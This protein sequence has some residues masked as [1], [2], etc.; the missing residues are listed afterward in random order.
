[1]NASV[2]GPVYLSQ[3]RLCTGTNMPPVT[4][5]RSVA[6]ESMRVLTTEADLRQLKRLYSM[7][8]DP[9]PEFSPTQ[10]IIAKLVW[11]DEGFF[12][13]CRKV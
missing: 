12:L 8:F 1:M 3:F 7:W 4:R 11:G 9:K 10:G 5:S 2:K 6:D 13:F